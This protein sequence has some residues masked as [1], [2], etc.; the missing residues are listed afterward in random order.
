MMI[1]FLLFLSA[2]WASVIFN[3]PA[4]VTVPNA[5]LITNFAGYNVYESLLR[6]FSTSNISDAQIDVK[7]YHN[8]RYFRVA[9]SDPLF[10]SQWHLQGRYGYGAGNRNIL[11]AI[12]DDGIQYTHPDLST[13]YRS[14]LSWNYIK[15][16]ADAAPS[17]SDGHGTA[18][19]GVCCAA[20]NNVCGRG[21]A[22][23]VGLVGVKVLDENDGLYDF[24][25]AQ[26]LAHRKDVIRIY[27]NSWGPPDDG[28]RMAGPGRI[29]AEVLKQH[30]MQQRTLVVWANGN[31]R[32]YSDRSDYDGYANSP[33]T[34]SIGAIDHKGKQAPYSESGA[35]LFAVAP[36]SG[37]GVGITTTDLM[38]PHGYDAGE[39]TARFGGSSAAAPLAA[40]IFALLL[41]E[42]PE[43]TVRDIQHIVAQNK[44]HSHEFG[45]GPLIVSE[46]LA[47]AK[48]HKLVKQPPTFVSV[49]SLAI[50]KLLIP[51]VDWLQIPL[52]VTESA[53]IERVM[54][55][56]T[57]NHGQRGQ[58]QV[59]LTSPSGSTSVLAATRRDRASGTFTWTFSSLYHWGEN[60]KGTWIVK[61]ND[62]KI[63]Q[64]TGYVE[65]AKLDFIAN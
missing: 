60:T 20:R 31:G 11:V 63:D 15:N 45:F 36:S 56:L 38:G 8:K 49:P 30:Y 44:T 29:T 19:A 2:S 35:A 58:V 27:S 42:R 47:K 22:F 41:S 65:R 13:N 40:G 46:L 1:V 55:T 4:H 51:T 3:V 16:N 26:A 64:Y 12:V 54:L 25:E 59:Q 7:Q 61:L 24:Q 50:N 37:D 62:G 21:V 39:C 53:T 14:D 9:E 52:E 10:P 17:P 48:Q 23:N 57:W 34:I 33:Y 6:S 28:M 18:A 5:R 43:L 32:E